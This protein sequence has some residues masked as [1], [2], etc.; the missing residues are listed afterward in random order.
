MKPQNEIREWVEHFRLRS[1]QD[2]VR[3]VKP[4]HT[5]S[6]SIQGIWTPFTNKNTT[7]NVT[8][9]PDKELSQFV[10]IEKTSSEKL[11]ELAQKLRLEDEQKNSNATKMVDS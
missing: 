9:F 7:D 5:D 4:W 1:G 10:P 8:T 11:L 6:P 2:L 3:L